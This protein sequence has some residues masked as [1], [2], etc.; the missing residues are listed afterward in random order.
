MNH[1]TNPNV[2]EFLDGYHR[3]LTGDMAVWRERAEADK[4]PIIL[5]ETEDLLAVIL[6]LKKPMRILEVGTA[7]GYSACFFAQYC[8]Q[9]KVVSIEIEEETAELARREVE[10]RGLAER[11][12]IISGDAAQVIN[13]FCEDWE[14]STFKGLETEEDSDF[15]RSNFDFFFIDGAKSQYDEFLYQARPILADEAIIICDNIL[16]G[17]MTADASYDSD[18]RY[19]TSIRR[20][21]TFMD[22][23][24]SRGD[25]DV[26]FTSAGDGLAICRLKKEI[27]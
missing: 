2:V 23:L 9:A 11:V 6:S 3:S 14:D 10:K 13:K 22:G 4:I 20:M 1:I 17:G 26:R 25:L 21:R 16:Q 15:P 27:D 7:V 8:R 5:R 18:K 24:S 12:E 19:R